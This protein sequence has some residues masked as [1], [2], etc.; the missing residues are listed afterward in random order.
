[1]TYSS[2]FGNLKLDV[3]GTYLASI[4]A[5]TAANFPNAYLKPLTAA[6]SRALTV[7]NVSFTAVCQEFAK[8]HLSESN[9]RFLV[10]GDELKIVVLRDIMVQLPPITGY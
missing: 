4:S 8:L 3:L 9:C 10:F 6:F 1:M 2:G 5:I 7:L